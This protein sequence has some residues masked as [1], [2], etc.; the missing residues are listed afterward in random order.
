MSSMSNGSTNECNDDNAFEKLAIVNIVTGGVSVVVSLILL[1]CLCHLKKHHFHSQRLIMYLNV[2]VCLHG[3]SSMLQF[4]PLTSKNVT[5]ASSYCKFI[6]VLTVYSEQVQLLIVILI[7]V[8]M[9]A[10]TVFHCY[11]RRGGEALEVIFALAFPLLYVWI[12][13]AFD[14]YGSTG[15]LCDITYVSIED[16]HKNKT[17]VLLVIFLC[18]LPQLVAF[19]AIIILNII[20]RVKLHR[21]KKQYR[22]VY[23]PLDRQETEILIKKLRSLQAYPFV[24]FI[25]EVIVIIYT[26]IDMVKVSTLSPY[27]QLIPIVSL[28]A[29][30]MAL[31]LAYVID[32]RTCSRITISLRKMMTFTRNRSH[33]VI[34]YNE[35]G[36]YIKYEES[37]KRM[38]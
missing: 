10:M 17:G 32:S 8:D 34:T 18:F 31:S 29:Q 15:A 35:S 25:F 12:P 22:G 21:E 5:E 4:H 28:N 16:C 19:F 36:M 23:N 20:L 7:V 9:F 14:S 13:L 30:G 11:A 33:S 38:K 2:T 37:L 6:G 3:L 24:Y 26:I 27:F 1:L